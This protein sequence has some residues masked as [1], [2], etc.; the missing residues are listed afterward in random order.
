MDRGGQLARALRAPLSSPRGACCF[1][2]KSVKQQPSTRV[3]ELGGGLLRS[4]QIAG[5]VQFESVRRLET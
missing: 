2:T 3:G 5:V 4:H 1:R